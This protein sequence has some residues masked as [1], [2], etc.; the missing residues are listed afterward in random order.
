MPQRSKPKEYQV[1]AAF[2][3][4]FVK[5][6]EWPDELFKDSTTVT[7]CIIGDDPF[8]SEIDTIQ[9]QSVKGKVLEVTRINSIDKAKNCHLL[10]ISSSERK[11]ITYILK[12]IKNLSVLT[13]GDTEGFAQQGVIINFF[14]EENKI[15]FEINTDAANCAKI[16]ISSKLLKLARIVGEGT[17]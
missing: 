5:F 4:N 17:K 6:I 2:I 10:F 9:G 13:I 1:K 7:F 3:Y 14:I 12:E 11:N 8:V 16:Q 15:R